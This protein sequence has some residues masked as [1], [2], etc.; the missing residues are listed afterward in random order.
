MNDVAKL[1]EALSRVLDPA[2]HLRL[3]GPYGWKEKSE[4]PPRLMERQAQE[5]R[6][7]VWQDETDQWLGRWI[8]ARRL[9]VWRLFAARLTYHAYWLAWNLVLDPPKKIDPELA[10][11]TSRL[12]PLRAMTGEAGF[13]CQSVR[14]GL[15]RLEYFQIPPKPLKAVTPGRRGRGQ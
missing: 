8:R 10:L 1:I 6:D 11:W 3:S 2:D 4:M 13:V 9:D 14:V 5:L 15:D 7:A 12:A